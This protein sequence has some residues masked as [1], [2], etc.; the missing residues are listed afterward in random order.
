MRQNTTNNK[1]LI[2]LSKTH[3]NFFFITK[4]FKKSNSFKLKVAKLYLLQDF[5]YLKGIYKVGETFQL[6]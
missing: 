2:F 1:I 4:I 5:D 6:E 3:D